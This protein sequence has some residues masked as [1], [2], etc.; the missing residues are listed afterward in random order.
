[1][2]TGSFNRYHQHSLGPLDWKPLSATSRV[3]KHGGDEMAPCGVPT[4]VVA[5]SDNDAG[6]LSLK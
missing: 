4:I 3:I 1:M 2:G 5:G 6:F